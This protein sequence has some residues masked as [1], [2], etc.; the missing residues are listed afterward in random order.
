MNAPVSRLLDALQARSPRERRMILLA[1]L[2]VAGALLVWLTEWTL[3]EHRRLATQL[4]TAQAQLVQMQADAAELSRLQTLPAPA[5]T[6]TE[7]LLGA[8]SAAASS[9]G[10][11]VSIERSGHLL[12][13]EGS[14]GFAALVDWLATL[15][16]E[17]RLR[18]AQVS[19]ETRGDTIHFRIALS[20]Q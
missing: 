1:M 17:Q 15:Q 20:P 16:A 3:A 6:P 19:M 4:P 5:T 2:V 14:G 9:R 10:L 13:A 18:A 12:Q 7:A 8:A 11:K